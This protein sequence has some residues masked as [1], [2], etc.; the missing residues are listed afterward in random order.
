MLGKLSF[1][2]KTC[3][4]ITQWLLTSLSFITF[5]MFLSIVLVWSNFSLPQL[6]LVRS[7]IIWWLTHVYWTCKAMCWMLWGLQQF[8]L[9]LKY[10]P[11]LPGLWDLCIGRVMSYC[12]NYTDGSWCNKCYKSRRSGFT[13][14]GF[15]DLTG[16]LGGGLSTCWGYYALV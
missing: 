3:F 1:I 9:L 16:L 5:K 15:W 13:G 14:P 8:I 10:Y 2:L 12:L 11:R 7:V 6:F 4:Q